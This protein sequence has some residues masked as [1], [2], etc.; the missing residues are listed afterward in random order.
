MDGDIDSAG[1]IDVHTHSDRIREGVYIFS[2]DPVSS[3]GFDRHPRISI[4]V[5][6]WSLDSANAGPIA[7]QAQIEAAL[8]RVEQQASSPKVVAIGECGL[9][10][11][12]ATS[13]DF[14]IEVFLRHVAI[15]GRVSKPMIVHCVRAHNEMI[16]LLKSVRVTVPVIVHGYNNNL[17]IAQQLLRAGIMV[18]FGAQ[19]SKENAP[20]RAVLAG[21]PADGFFLETDDRDVG[22][23]EVY[24][25]AAQCRQCSLDKLITTLRANYDRVFGTS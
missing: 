21:C 9:D 10:K 18:S 24:A 22:I 25:A 13:L 14:Q 20:I 15:A 11:L 23:G 5:H 2:A 12:I 4:G 3:I 7:S 8:D 19:I 6:P 1:Y 16:R 17:Q